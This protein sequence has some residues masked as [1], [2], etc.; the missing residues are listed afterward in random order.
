MDKLEVLK[1]PI[2]RILFNFP[3][4]VIAF[5]ILNYLIYGKISFE[6]P[7]EISNHGSLDNLEWLIYITIAI[8]LGE[9]VS[10]IGEFP[11]N[12]L[13]K[14]NPILDKDNKKPSDNN[15][16]ELVSPCS[17]EW[18]YY[19]DF[20]R[21]D[22]RSL[23]SEIH[24]SI[25]RTLA[26]FGLEMLIILIITNFKLFC[27]PIISLITSTN[28]EI[29]CSSDLEFLVFITIVIFFILLIILSILLSFKT[30]FCFIFN[31]IFYFIVISL[32]LIF[33]IPINPIPVI[34]IYSS[35]FSY[36]GAIYYRAHANRLINALRKMD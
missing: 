21:D 14:Y 32:F 29:S 36:L 9:V 28:F 11:L 12:I 13:F 24:F 10:F 8:L 22:L 5:G 4:G 15:K 23:S 6:F 1:I 33:L 3:I 16:M 20:K 7:F 18:I 19:E 26:G 31:F 25:S 27:A 34:I 2:Y 35:L 30:I 17:D